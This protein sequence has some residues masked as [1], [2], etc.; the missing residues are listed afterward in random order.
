MSNLEYSGP[1]TKKAAFTNKLTHP[2]LLD[3]LLIKQFN[4]GYLEWE[5]ETCWSEIESEFGVAVSE[6][7]RHKVQAVKT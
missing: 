3:L 5:P 6:V 4:T 7:N 2:L 1:F